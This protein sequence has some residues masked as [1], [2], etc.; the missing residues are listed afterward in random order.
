[1]YSSIPKSQEIYGDFAEIPET[2]IESEDITQR[3][4]GESFVA[5]LQLQYGAEE[6]GQRQTTEFYDTNS[7]ANC[8]QFQL[9]FTVKIKQISPVPLNLRQ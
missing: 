4:G 6:I 8:Q 1:V 2:R 7:A 3:C 5:Q 9:Q